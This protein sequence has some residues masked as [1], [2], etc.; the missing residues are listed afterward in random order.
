M[1]I[2][3][4]SLSESITILPIEVILHKQSQDMALGD[5][6]S[7]LCGCTA[8]QGP[9]GSCKHIVRLWMSSIVSRPLYNTQHVHQNCRSGIS[10]KKGHSSLN[11]LTRSKQ[12]MIPAHNTF[13][14]LSDNEVEQFC[15]RLQSLSKPCGFLQVIT[16][17]SS[18]PTIT[19]PVIPRSVRD[20]VLMYRRSMDHLLSLADNLFWAAGIQ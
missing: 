15:T 6:K 12:C 3:Y 10:H 20:R 18:V 5:I 2:T 1:L 4:L 19:L 16:P 7:V 8:G 14:I 9:K 13:S 11:M 17:A